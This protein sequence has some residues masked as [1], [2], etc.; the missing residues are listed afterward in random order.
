MLQSCR[1]SLYTKITHDNFFFKLFFYGHFQKSFCGVNNDTPLVRRKSSNYTLMGQ[2]YEKNGKFV[3]FSKFSYK[4]FPTRFFGWPFVIE[5]CYCLFGRN[6]AR[7]LST[8]KPECIGNKIDIDKSKFETSFQALTIKKCAR[9]K[10][11]VL[12]WKYCT[13]Y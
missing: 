13:Y 6:W 3:L 2:K 7:P 12:W 9:I 4:P 8:A 11:N 1:R 5:K 10:N